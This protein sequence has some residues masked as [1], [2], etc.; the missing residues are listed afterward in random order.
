MNAPF[1]LIVHLDGTGIFWD[2]SERIHLD[3]LVAWCHVG[4]S[5]PSPSEEPTIPV[6]M[7]FSKWKTP[8][9]DWG[10]RASALAPEGPVAF[11]TETI[12]KRLDVKRIETTHGSLSKRNG[13]FKEFSR[14]LHLLLCRRLVG[15]FHGDAPA[16]LEALRSKVTHLGKKRSSG[17][18]KVIGYEAAPVEADWSCVRDGIAM[19]ALPDPNGWRKMRVSPP[20]WH[21]YGAINVCDPGTPYD[22]P[23]VSL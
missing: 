3:S 8:A 1:K 9:G 12:R 22:R 16:V 15:Y 5:V 7:P 17:F 10:F 6:R 23:L 13:R 18:G 2:D 14:P 20:Y 21:R 4:G 19:R 11:S